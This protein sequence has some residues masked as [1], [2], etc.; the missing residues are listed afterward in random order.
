[1]ILC[2]SMQLYIEVPNFVQTMFMESSTFGLLSMWLIEGSRMMHTHFNFFFFIW[3]SQIYKVLHKSPVMNNTILYFL[4]FGTKMFYSLQWKITWSIS[5]KRRFF[6]R[7]NETC[8]Y[9]NVKNSWKKIE[10]FPA[11]KS[12]IWKNEHH[13]T[14][15]QKC[16]ITLC[17]PSAIKIIKKLP[18]CQSCLMP[19]SDIRTTAI[20]Y[21][22]CNVCIIPL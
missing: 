19:S 11:R 9:S 2:T 3:T 20:I 13:I 14:P 12:C 18:V 8:F 1:M 21:F 15:S 5:S 6:Q 4:A 22:N 17:F 10:S 7:G 16:V